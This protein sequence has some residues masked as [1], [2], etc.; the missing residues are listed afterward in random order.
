M[1]LKDFDPY[2]IGKMVFDDFAKKFTGEGLYYGGIIIN[3][4]DIK[5]VIDYGISLEQQS[6]NDSTLNLIYAD[7]ELKTFVGN[8]ETDIGYSEIDIANHLKKQL[9]A[10]L[11]G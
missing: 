10:L 3:T 1:K 11:R 9:Y 6:Y 8:E 2:L 4:D 5:V 7:L